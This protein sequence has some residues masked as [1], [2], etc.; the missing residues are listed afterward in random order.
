MKRMIIVIS[1]A[2]ICIVGSAQAKIIRG[3]GADLGF[4]MALGQLGR[5]LDM[6]Y[7]GCLIVQ[8]PRILV[9]VELSLGISWQRKKETE[10]TRLVLLPIFLS[11]VIDLRKEVSRDG[12][13][14]Y[15]RFGFGG[16]FER[17]RTT[18]QGSLSNF[19]PGLLAGVGARKRI[20]RRLFLS[21]ELSYLFIYQSYLR[22][23]EFNGR[24]AKFGLGA[25]YQF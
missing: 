11:G 25:V 9:P 12:I 10:N 2:A 20:G 3:L 24:L 22:R 21:L 19:D 17:A 7:S 13:L 16:I 4:I 15:L 23:A 8:G 14:P 5:N 6:G 1:L 18:Y